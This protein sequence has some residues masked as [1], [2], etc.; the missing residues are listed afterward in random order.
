MAIQEYQLPAQDAPFT[1]TV[2]YGSKEMTWLWEHRAE[3]SAN[4]VAILRNLYDSRNKGKLI[5]EINI[6]YKLKP[7]AQ[8]FGRFYSVKGP[9]S[10]QN[11]I[12]ATLLNNYYWDIDICNCHPNLLHQFAE[13]YFGFEL[14]EIKSY[15]DNRDDYLTKFSTPEEGKQEFIKTI[16]GGTSDNAL[17]YTC[18]AQI[19]GFVQFLKQQKMFEPL[20]G[21]C[22]N[23]VKNP[24]SRFR[25][26]RGGV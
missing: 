3:F 8:G 22:R 2:L 10:L 25:I 1:T 13:R 12:R 24:R 9:E 19:D 11:E 14:S 21:Y 4:D 17:L 26:R 18:R 15:V 20:L 5:R 23:K 7:E 16:N 6:T